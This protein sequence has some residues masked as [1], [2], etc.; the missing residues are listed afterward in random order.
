MRDH[1]LY[2]TRSGHSAA[3]A[4]V[5][6]RF[7]EC[8]MRCLRIFGWYLRGGYPTNSGLPTA[9]TAYRSSRW[10]QPP[11]RG[12]AGCA[13]RGC[14]TSGV[15]FVFSGVFCLYY[16]SSAS[17]WQ[18]FFNKQNFNSETWQA[19]IDNIYTD[20]L[21]VLL[22]LFSFLLFPPSVLF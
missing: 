20:T 6:S 7:S 14:S 18:L 22:L 13:L 8:Y 21:A 10:L 9:F 17:V 15:S 16:Y 2:F 11:L 12:G 5:S 4:H 3:A 19:E 1:S